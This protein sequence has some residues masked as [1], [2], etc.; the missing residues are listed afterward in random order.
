M[1]EKTARYGLGDVLL[2]SLGGAGQ[3]VSQRQIASD[4]GGIRAAS[5]VRPNALDE[6]RAQQ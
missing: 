3:N 5:A 2:G 1:D 4:R 6:W